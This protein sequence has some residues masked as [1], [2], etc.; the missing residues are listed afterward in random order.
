MD[1]AQILKVSVKY[2]SLL[3]VTGATPRKC[4][5]SLNIGPGDICAYEHCL[6]MCEEIRKVALSDPEKAVRWLCFIQGILWV[7]GKASIDSMR[8]DNRLILKAT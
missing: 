7:S 3:Q 1:T 4:D 5:T 2:E 8:E 6:W